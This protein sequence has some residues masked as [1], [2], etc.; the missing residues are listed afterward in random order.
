MQTYKLNS[1]YRIPMLGLGT[2]KSNIEDELQTAIKEAIRIGYRHID[3]AKIY[4][5]EKV[6]GATLNEL[7]EECVVKRE[8]LF[9]TSK[10]WNN[11]HAKEDVIP[12]LKSTLKDLQLDY[13][14]LYLIHWPICFQKDTIFPTSTK[15]FVSLK[16]VPISQTWESMEEAVKQGLVRS[17]GVSNFSVKKL[18]ELDKTAKIKPSVNQV[19][20]HPFLQQEKLLK[21][22]NSKN[23]AVTA[24]SPLGSKDRAAFVRSENEPS[25]LDNTIIN[26]IAK[27][28]G[29]SPAQVLIK[30]QLQRNVIV[31]PK[32]V[33][34][35]R[36]KENF[37]SQFV[38]LDDEDVKKISS[39]DK[40]FRYVNGSFFTPK[41]SG[42]TLQN[43]WDEDF[44]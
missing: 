26:E 17:I 34:P 23:I 30:W 22:C 19:E 32:S 33:N 31:I 5:N 18:K 40:N 7:F 1:G 10:L 3:C 29:V 41:G 27:K 24:Y 16:N 37:D 28:H 15:E 12:A 14:D 25:L 4:E 20:S 35:A 38:T 9:I 39:L 42:Y 44:K 6:I 11:S 36:L 8:E 2:W 21:Y 13:L 43:L